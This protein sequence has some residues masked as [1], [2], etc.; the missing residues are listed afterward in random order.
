MHIN[1]GIDWMRYHLGEG[2]L[3]LERAFQPPIPTMKAALLYLDR[4]EDQ[5]MECIPCC[6]H[7]DTRGYCLGHEEHK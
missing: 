3:S 7:H 2:N 4:L 5:G 6:D 1:I